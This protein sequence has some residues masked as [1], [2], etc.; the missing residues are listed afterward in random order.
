ML[1]LTLVKIKSNAESVTENPNRKATSDMGKYFLKLYLYP[2]RARSVRARRACALRALGLLKILLV[3]DKT[4]KLRLIRSWSTWV[5][6][7]YKLLT[8]LNFCK[9]RECYWQADSVWY[10]VIRNMKILKN[11]QQGKRGDK[12]KR[13]TCNHSVV[14]VSSRIHNTCIASFSSIWNSGF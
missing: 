10:S 3:V 12:N 4:T 8:V 14:L 2:A 5:Y 1:W 11:M 13:D 9:N 7:F 6:H